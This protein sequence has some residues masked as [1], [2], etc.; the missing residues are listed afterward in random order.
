MEFEEHSI[1]ILKI[2]RSVTSEQKQQDP[3][4][5]LYLVWDYLE[6]NNVPTH[7]IQSYLE[8]QGDYLEVKALLAEICNL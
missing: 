4:Y 6:S 5:G 2:M 1:E 7:E 8:S 3:Q